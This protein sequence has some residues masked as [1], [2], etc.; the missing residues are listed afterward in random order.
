[1]GSSYIGRNRETR[2]QCNVNVTVC[3]GKIQI[4]VPVPCLSHVVVVV[5]L[6]IIA[7]T[8]RE[9][10]RNSQKKRGVIY[11]DVNVIIRFHQEKVGYLCEESTFLQFLA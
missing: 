10:E 6:S 11:K 4:T 3:T 1:V 8:T 7:V 2:D 9:L 5:V